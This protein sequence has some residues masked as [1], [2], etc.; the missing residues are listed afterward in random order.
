M[1][2]KR[3]D[4]EGSIR[5]RRDGGWEA[6]LSLPEG[7]RKSVYGKTRDEAVR[8]LREAQRARD[9]GLP[10]APAALTVRQW[11]LRWVETAASRVRPSTAA[12]YRQLVERQVVPTWGRIRLSQLTPA[13]VERGL[14]MLLKTGLS[15]RTV[16]HVR[17]VLRTS[18]NDAQRE[19]LL[20]RNVATLAKAP[21][22][23]REVPKVLDPSEVGAVVA[24]MPDDGL[25]RLVIV[26]VHTGLRQ[27]ELLGLRWSDVNLEVHELHVTQALQRVAGRYELVDVKSSTSR[28]TIPL[29]AAAV[30]TLEDQRQWQMEA[31]LAA[32]GRWHELIPGLVFTTDR[33][34]PVNGP[35]L[36]H[37]FEDALQAT[38]LPVIRWHHLRHAY[39]GLALGSGSDL[40]T[41]SGLLGH[42]SVALTASTY[43]GIMPSLKRQAAD[44]LGDLLKV[45]G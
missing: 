34:H 8:R 20:A 2:G 9:Q 11:C 27:G 25:R 28:R 40:A 37:R 5:R 15:P 17:A 7:S 29:T 18:L 26:A 21:R 35:S 10:F 44:R 42:S 33:G 16:G 19:G 6:R 24:A 45:P 36:T 38:G 1:T 22:V 32:G 12:R 3:A 13:E 4:G 43:A 23:P 39:A 31:R 41:V 14:E 30:S